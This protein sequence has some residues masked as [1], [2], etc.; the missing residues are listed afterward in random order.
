MIH[1]VEKNHDYSNENER[2]ILMIVQESIEQLHFPKR[3]V[4][5]QNDEIIERKKTVL[6]LMSRLNSGIISV[7]IFFEDISGAKKVI[8]KLEEVR[9]NEL[10]ISQ[11][12]RIP[13][14]RIRKIQ[15][16]DLDQKNI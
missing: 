15:L 5:R 9:E 12:I 11:K 10:I 14:H 7:L 13:L 8:A 16:I 2:E 1:S 3:E 4:L 6:N